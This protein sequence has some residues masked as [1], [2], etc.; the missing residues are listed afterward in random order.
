MLEH[1]FLLIA[2]S[3]D[4]GA[5]EFF[6]KFK[7]EIDLATKGKALVMKAS[8]PDDGAIMVQIYPKSE[9]F[10]QLTLETMPALVAHITQNADT[11]SLVTKNELYID[12]LATLLRANMHFT[13]QN[14]CGKCYPCRL[15]GPLIDQLLASYQTD[16]PVNV[17]Q[18][19]NQL[20]DVGISMKSASMCAIGIF[21]ADPLLFAMEKWP[22]YFSTHQGA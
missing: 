22:T 10:T 14:I 20:Q 18:I 19:V 21:G 15:G 5:D 16:A 13:E 6:K 12:D 4:K 11:S 1:D 2:V 7:R 3:A 17:T 8:L 9:V